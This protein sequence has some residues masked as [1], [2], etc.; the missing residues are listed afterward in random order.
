MPRSE[1][2]TCTCLENMVVRMHVRSHA[3]V[4]MYASTCVHADVST[5]E[6]MS[7]HLFSN[8]MSYQSVSKR[9]PW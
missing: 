6:H 2:I 7:A 5:F 1:K 3:V 4:H 9:E 8:H